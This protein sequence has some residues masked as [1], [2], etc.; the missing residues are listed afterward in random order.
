M[1][2]YIKMA[3]VAVIAVLSF[4]ACSDDDDN[5]NIV[6]S[7]V[8]KGD[9]N[10]DMSVSLESGVPILPLIEGQTLTLTKNG[11]NKVDIVTAFYIPL[12][13]EDELTV[14]IAVTDINLTGNEEKINLSYNGKIK[15]P[16]DLASPAEPS[17]EMMSEEEDE[18]EYAEVDGVISG[19]IENENIHMD[20]KIDDT[21]VGT[22][23]IGVN[24]EKQ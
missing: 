19:T 18:I 21:I 7:D 20:I 9:Y 1:K 24:G 12:S 17:E 4:T 3:A 6:L 5:N 8:A 11:D 2:K 14:P 23:L 13:L 16:K 22:L 10:V 15:I